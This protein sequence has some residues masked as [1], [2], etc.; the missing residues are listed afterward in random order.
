MSM[1][2]TLDGLK[3]AIRMEVAQIDRA[4]LERVEANFQERLQKCINKNGHHMKDIV[5]PNINLSNAT[6]MGTQ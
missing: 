3:E 1:P 4:M 5:F 6:S 2:R